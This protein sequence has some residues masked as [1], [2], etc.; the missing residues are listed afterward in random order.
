[1]KKPL[2]LTLCLTLLL[3]GLVLPSAALAAEKVTGPY[4]PDPEV[5]FRGKISFNTEDWRI[6]SHGLCR[7]GALTLSDMDAVTAYLSCIAE[8]YSFTQTAYAHDPGSKFNSSWDWYDDGVFFSY[9]GKETLDNVSVESFESRYVGITPVV[10]C[11]HVYPSTNTLGLSIYYNGNISFR[12][13]GFVYDGE[14]TVP[15]QDTHHDDPWPDPSHSP[16]PT[17]SPRRCSACGGDGKRDCSTCGGTGKVKRYV[18]GSGYNGIGEGRYEWRT[19][20]SCN[21]YGYK[22]C[23]V[24]GGDGKIGD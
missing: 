14:I 20:S 16:M 11:L 5:F 6:S 21:G 23:Y 13:D 9:N 10:V 7:E 15:D 18:S 24:C 4:L 2:C 1:M 17:D 3:A 19:C 8:H 12:D 22:T